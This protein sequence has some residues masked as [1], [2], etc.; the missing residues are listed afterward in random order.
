M[1]IR[2]GDWRRP[3]KEGEPLQQDRESLK[4]LE[5]LKRS[6]PEVFSAQYMQDPVPEAGNMLKREW[7]KWYE[8][9]LV[10]QPGDLIVCPA[11][12]P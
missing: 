1:M 6:N 4:V 8:P 12:W 2:I 10:R 3:W 11:I 9:P 7:I 5:E